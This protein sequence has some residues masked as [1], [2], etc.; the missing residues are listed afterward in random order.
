MSVWGHAKSDMAKR[1]YGT[2]SSR[3][4]AIADGTSD[5]DGEPFYI[6]EGECPSGSEMVPDAD[7]IIEM[8]GEWPADNF[9]G[10]LVDDG[11]PHVTD[12]AKAELN[13]LL[14]AWAEKH[15]KVSFWQGVDSPERIEPGGE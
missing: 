14:E 13:T 7:Q 10:E 11:F 15:I 12:E 1:F 3:E 9:L 2:F 6:L 8:I 4:D 5:Y